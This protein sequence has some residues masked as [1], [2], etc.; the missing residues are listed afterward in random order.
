MLLSQAG[1]G[2]AGIDLLSYDQSWYHRG[3]GALVI[4]LWDLVQAFLIRPS[5]HPF[6]GW[7]RFWYRIFGASIGENVLLRNSVKCNYPWRLS[8]GRNSWI[9][10]EATLYCLQH[11]HIGENAV[12]SQQSYLCS[13][14]HNHRDPH[15]GLIVKP[16]VVEDGAWVAL[17]ALV[18][19][20]VTV[21]AGALVGARAVLTKDAQPWTIYQGLPAHPAGQRILDMSEH[22][23]GERVHR[24]K[25]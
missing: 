14:T 17:G 21:G 20:G 24:E 18:M 1:P 3:R 7:R 23:H 11:V 16:I 9:G 13:G 22:A 5:P 10:D 2:N 4:I 12:I 8:I 15:F 19:P 25:E 6:Y